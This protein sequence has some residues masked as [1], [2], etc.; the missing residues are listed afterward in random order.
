[1]P[2]SPQLQGG[3]AAQNQ[4]RKAWGGA[5]PMGE[6]V[7]GSREH[8]QMAQGTAASILLTHPSRPWTGHTARSY[9]LKESHGGSDRM[10][11]GLWG[12]GS[13]QVGFLL[14]PPGL[15][16]SSRTLYLLPWHPSHQSA[17]CREAAPELPVGR[18]RLRKQVRKPGAGQ[19]AAGELAAGGRQRDARRSWECQVSTSLPACQAGHCH[20][21][22]GPAP[23]QLPTSP[24]SSCP[25]F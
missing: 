18:K 20:T 6:L 15:S 21:K 4:L 3:G 12:V 1:M 14:A 13:R 16:F 5:A 17:L 11:G 2:E 24:G 9:A 25:P 7:P 8:L 22:H 10:G 23:A 19:R